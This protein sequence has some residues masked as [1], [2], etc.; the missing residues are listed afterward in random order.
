MTE[1]IITWKGPRS[2]QHLSYRSEEPV[3]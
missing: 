1:N 2:R 3:K